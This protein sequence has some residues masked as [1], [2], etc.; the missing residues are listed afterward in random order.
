MTIDITPL[1]VLQLREL[2]ELANERIVQ[3]QNS[4]RDEVIRAAT[5]AA[6]ELGFEDLKA[7]LETKRPKRGRKPGRPRSNGHNQSITQH[8]E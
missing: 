3:L 6:L 5:E 7:L 2:I 4:K 8:Q 1:S